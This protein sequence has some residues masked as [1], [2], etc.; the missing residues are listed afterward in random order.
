MTGT[1]KRNGSGGE[2]IAV[3]HIGQHKTGTTSI[4][5]AF[6]GYDDGGAFYAPFESSNH[7]AAMYAGFSANPMNYPFWKNHG[8]SAEEFR[9]EKERFLAKFSEMLNR[10]DRIRIIISSEEVWRLESAGKAKLIEFIRRHGWQVRVIAY[11]REPASWAASWICEPLKGKG[12]AEIPC[13]IDPQYR[14]GLSAFAELLPPEHLYIRPFDP[15]RLA[16]G[17]IVSN[18]CKALDIPRVN[19]SRRNEA[20]SLSAMKL[21]FRFSKSG[22]LARGDAVVFGTRQKFVRLIAEKYSG[23]ERLDPALCEGIADYSE[24]DWLYET[25]GIDFRR[26]TPPDHSHADLE[27]VL[28]DLSNVDLSGLDELLA[29]YGVRHEN[30]AAVEEKLHR[31]FYVFLSLDRGAFLFKNPGRNLKKNFHYRAL[32]HFSKYRVLPPH[33]RET[34]KRAATALR[35]GWIAGAGS[36]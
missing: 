2:R 7:S 36:R 29:E 9:L 12:L 32:K 15:N 3:L 26:T 14:L 31:L 20:L 10:R 8:Y 11:V 4:Q 25:F 35:D 17:D 1:D 33:R 6:A 19:I 24:T 28:N 13:K 27:A 22:S 23:L 30:F 18:F 5:S 16:E 34:L 21:L